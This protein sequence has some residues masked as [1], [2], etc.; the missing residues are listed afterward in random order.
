MS[1]SEEGGSNWLV[2]I[3]VIGLVIYASSW[4]WGVIFPGNSKNS[5][6]SDYSSYSN[7]VNNSYQK[8]NDCIEPENPYNPGTGHYAGFEWGEQGN[9]C[10][11]NSDSFVEGCEEYEFQDELYT[12]C[13]NNK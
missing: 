6:D 3:I 4:L 1:H 5:Y 10:S 13:E 11:G 2:N 9:Y 8:T 7:S 12:E